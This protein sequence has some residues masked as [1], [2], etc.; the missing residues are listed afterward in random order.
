MW[1]DRGGWISGPC[2]S[3][4]PGVRALLAVVADALSLPPSDPALNGRVHAVT[5]SLRTALDSAVSDLDLK[6]L[7]D[8]LREQLDLVP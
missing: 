5:G 4:D 6:I 1:I 8:L 2:R 3:L 7:A